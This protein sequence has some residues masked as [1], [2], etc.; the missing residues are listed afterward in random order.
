MVIEIHDDGKVKW[1]L[2]NPPHIFV[3]DKWAITGN[4]KVTC[5]T[6]VGI[7]KSNGQLLAMTDN[8]KGYPS[9]H[10]TVMNMYAKCKMK[11]YLGNMRDYT[12]FEWLLTTKQF[13]G[14]YIRVVSP[15]YGDYLMD[16]SFRIPERW[17]I[18]Q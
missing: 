8:W 6:K 3:G 10:G 14:A 12:I 9:E 15:V 5:K 17:Y 16:F 11:T 4:R 18:K 1:W 2:K 13:K 7:Y